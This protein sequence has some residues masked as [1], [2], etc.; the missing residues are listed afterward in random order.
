MCF[1][2][3]KL[4][5]LKS[6]RYVEQEP[7]MNNWKGT[8]QSFEKNNPPVIWPRDIHDTFC[9]N[10]WS[11]IN[12]VIWKKLIHYLLQDIIKIWLKDILSHESNK[13]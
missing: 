7:Q 12:T 3:R 6:L 2:D 10:K 9:C 4:C 8:D 13:N 5:R 11:H 1:T